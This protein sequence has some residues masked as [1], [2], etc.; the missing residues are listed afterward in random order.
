MPIHDTIFGMN[1]TNLEK[2]IKPSWIH[3]EK[4]NFFQVTS[5]HIYIKLMD[6][7]CD[8]H[9]HWVAIYHQADI[10]GVTSVLDIV[11]P[12]FLCKN[13]IQTWGL[14]AFFPHR[15]PVLCMHERWLAP[16]TFQIT[17]HR[18][19]ASKDQ[20][21]EKCKWCVNFCW[22]LPKRTVVLKCFLE[23]WK[24]CAVISTLDYQ[25]I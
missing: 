7:T 23:K 17:Y 12:W 8:W 18:H 5:F 22:R 16:S 24:K 19:K 14:E 9:I 15:L 10:C 13:H 1:S 2:Y 20:K 21:L 6:S 3:S 25:E 11:K 4:S